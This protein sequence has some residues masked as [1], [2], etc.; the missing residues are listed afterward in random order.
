MMAF[1]VPGKHAA[2]SR[3]FQANSDYATAAVIRDG[4]FDDIVITAAV[5]GDLHALD[6]TMRGELFWMRLQNGNLSRLLAVNA[7]FFR[8]GGEVLF[9]SKEPI[10]YVQ[11]YFWDG[12]IVIEHGDKS[13]G[14]VYVRDLRDRQFQRY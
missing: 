4:E 14:K 3:R 7:H 13:E 6:C 10:S 12:G 1:L 5:D 2:E 8:F 9:E 11:A